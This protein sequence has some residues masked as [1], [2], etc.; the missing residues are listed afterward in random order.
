[1][2][3]AGACNGRL[4][5]YFV[6][7]LL[8]LPLLRKEGSSFDLMLRVGDVFSAMAVAVTVAVGVEVRDDDPAGESAA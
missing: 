6:H 5:G 4:E 3:A 8:V 7:S 2:A 1:M